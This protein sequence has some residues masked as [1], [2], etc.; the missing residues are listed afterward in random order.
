MSN[1]DIDQLW[2]K[3][4]AYSVL[5]LLLGSGAYILCDTIITL[6]RAHASRG[7]PTTPGRIQM[8][9]HYCLGNRQ[10]AVWYSYYLDGVHYEST[11]VDLPHLT[12]DQVYEA[13]KHGE[14]LPVHYDPHRPE[15]SVL[16][17]GFVATRAVW[18][19]GAILCFSWGFA[20][21]R[22]QSA[23]NHSVSNDRL[24]HAA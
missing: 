8:V 22:N 17:P 14:S 5:L 21:M 7:W 3:I 19:L 12:V 18:F 15:I 11:T 16:D 20:W 10:I 6:H 1:L 23:R 9:R 4:S 2:E 13:A 24:C